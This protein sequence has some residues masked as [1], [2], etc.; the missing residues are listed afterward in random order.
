MFKARRHA[1]AIA[2]ASI[3]AI[4][5]NAVMLAQG[6]APQTVARTPDGQLDIQGIWGTDAD[7]ADMETGLPDNET[8]TLQGQT[9]DRS[10]ERS[11]V[12]DPP[13]RRIPYQ[14]WAQQRRM[15]IPTF[16]RGE[17]SRGKPATVRDIRPRTFCL[18]GTPRNMT[19]DFQ[20]VQ[21]PDQ[22]ILMW[23]FNHA[24]RTIRLG[25]TP[26]LPDTVKLAMGDSRGRWDGN[27][28]VVETSNINDWDWFDYTGTFHSDRT[29]LLE[30]FTVV[31]AKTIDYQATVTD[32]VVFTRPWTYGFQLRRTRMAGDGYEF[33][34]HACV[35][36]ERGV[37]ALLTEPK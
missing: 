11:L 7:A 29:T 10:K 26:A 13:D 5:G 17:T 9:V 24:Y 1:A 25:N 27:T 20:V 21:T 34:E 16:R 33:L 18:H 32:P 30:R 4:G 8:A 31:D 2:I 14:P 22:V 6:G 15:S 3:A 36:G 37:D 35:E 28:L 19:T 12:I 23:E